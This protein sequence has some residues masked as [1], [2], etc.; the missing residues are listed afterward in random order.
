LRFSKY[1]LEANIENSHEGTA[2]AKSQLVR[3]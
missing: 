1:P 2:E 3:A